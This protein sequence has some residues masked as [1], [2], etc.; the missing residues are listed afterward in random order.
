MHD[1]HGNKLYALVLEGKMFSSLNVHYLI[2]YFHTLVELEIKSSVCQCA[3]KGF[4]VL[5][6]GISQKQWNA[7]QCINLLKFRSIVRPN[8]ANTISLSAWFL[9]EVNN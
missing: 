2:S 9:Y 8:L 6:L 3:A 4:L 1:G 5:L 7:K